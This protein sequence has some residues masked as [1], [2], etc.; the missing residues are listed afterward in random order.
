MRPPLTTSITVPCTGVPVSWASSIRF[1]A[2]SK[3]AR[4]LLRMR[5]PSASSF[6]MTSASI[7]SP[8]CTS[9][10]VLTFLRMESSLTGMT[11]SLLYPMSTR[12]S[13]LSMRT[14]F[15][16]TMSPSVKTVMVAS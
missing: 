13:S 16:V 8:S 10:A 12:T 14:T 9:S 1:Q 6:C 3:R 5:R 2:F 15:P 11:P 7:S 4:F